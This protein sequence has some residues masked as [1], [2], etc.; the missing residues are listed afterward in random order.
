MAR[1]RG[2]RLLHRYGVQGHTAYTRQARK[3][4][5]GSVQS[6]KSIN[7][8]Y[9]QSIDATSGYTKALVQLLQGQQA[10]AAGAYQE[11]IDQQKQIDA[12][13]Q[14]QLGA[15]GSEIAPTAAAVQGVGD[16]AMSRLLSGQAA[17][18]GYTS[19]EPGIASARGAEGLLGLE[20]QR[21]DALDTRREQIAAQVP[22]LA[23]Q[24]RQQDVSNAMGLAGYFAQ[25]RQNRISN[26]FQQEGL[27]MQQQQLNLS[28]AGQAQDE[29]HWRAEFGAQYGFD[30]YTG[31][32]VRGS[33]GGGGGSL[34]AWAKSHGFTPSQVQGMRADALNA[35][36]GKPG[37]LKTVPVY[38]LVDPQTGKAGTRKWV[39]VK[40]PASVTEGTNLSIQITDYAQKEVGGGGS[41]W[42]NG[43]DF[44]HA[45]NNI[46]DHGIAPLPIAIMAVAQRYRRLRGADWGTPQHSSYMSY[47]NFIRA[48]QGLPPQQSGMGQ[49]RPDAGQHR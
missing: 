28:A 16:S 20:H 44:Q 46:V 35:L 4:A 42:D 36:D 5:S 3:I 21:Q 31:K 47:I 25:Q 45:V 12:A 30:P 7:R 39:G 11:A 27:D 19:K 18:G 41:A 14:Q 37:T 40:P 9:Q 32:T 26:R 1:N 29:Q 15:L 23:M 43:W 38:Q 22:G 49:N 8:Q 24:L 2:N 17:I 33:G 13:A 34:G 10:P 6:S 48:G